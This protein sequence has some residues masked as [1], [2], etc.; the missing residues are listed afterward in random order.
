MRRT[1][2]EM[3]GGF[4]ETYR[5][6]SIEDIE[7][8][9]RLKG[10]GYRIKLVKSLQVTHWKRWTLS[11]I[12]LTDVFCRA[13]PW[14]ALMLSHHRT[15]NDLNLQM[16]GRISTLLAGTMVVGVG[17]ALRWRWAI[18]IV[19]LAMMGLLAL[20]HRLY[21]WFIKKRGLFFSLRAIP[22]HWAY[23]LYSGLTFGAGALRFLM[24]SWTKP[25]LRASVLKRTISVKSVQSEKSK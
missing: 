5:T 16:S 2:F 6:S 10:A 21:R 12:V 25:T 4:G 19:G 11:S 23:F 14:T 22:L 15:L 18:V 13:L 9:Y 24:K 1:V 8:G 7:I 17:V 3:V 20:N